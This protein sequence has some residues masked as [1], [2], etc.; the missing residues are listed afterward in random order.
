MKYCNWVVQCTPILCFWTLIKLR[1]ICLKDCLNVVLLFH[2]LIGFTEHQTGGIN[3]VV[4]W[5]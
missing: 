1:E 3:I 2:S 4:K 5:S